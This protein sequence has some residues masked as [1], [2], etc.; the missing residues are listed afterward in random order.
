M[1]LRE[2]DVINLLKPAGGSM[3]IDKRSGNWHCQ[4]R[5]KAEKIF[6]WSDEF[7]IKSR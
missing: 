4:K 1:A 2:R 5:V 3:D 7:G 6:Y